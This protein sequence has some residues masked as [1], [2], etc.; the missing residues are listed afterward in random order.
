MKHITQMGDLPGTL[1]QQ[2]AE[3]IVASFLK[4]EDVADSMMGLATELTEPFIN[5]E[6]Q[7]LFSEVSGMVACALAQF[8]TEAATGDG[9]LPD[10]FG[11]TAAKRVVEGEAKSLFFAFRWDTTPQ[12]DPY[13]QFRWIGGAPL[14][15]GDIAQIERWINIAESQNYDT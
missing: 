10:A 7:D 3:S 15:D 14:S 9:T 1:K 6:N 13:W 12:G 11:V 4:D 8:F 5:P 2:I